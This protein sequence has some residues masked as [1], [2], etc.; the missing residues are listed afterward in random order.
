MALKAD[1]ICW[2]LLLCLAL[3][4]SAGQLYRWVDE[5]GKV[6]YSDKP[7]VQSKSGTATLS[8]QGTV[9]K[10]TEGELTPEQKQQREADTAKAKAEAEAREAAR[11]RD[12]ALLSTFNSVA[13]ID[14]KRD[15]NLQQVQGELTSLKVRF[16]STEG[17]LNAYY[18]QMAQYEKNKRT[19]PASLKTDIAD[20]EAELVKIKQ[21]MDEKQKSV[22]VIRQ[23]A[24]A[25]KKRYLELKS[26]A[27]MAP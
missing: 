13:E 15:R 6:Q 19:V 26:G 5:N 1:S 10:K 11:L 24:E 18:T 23:A 17:R 20:T 27:P 25:D 14:R 12:K 22:E 7:P 16:K 8:K 2:G 3:P 21:Q 9:V 4:V